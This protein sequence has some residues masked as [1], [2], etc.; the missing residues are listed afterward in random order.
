MMEFVLRERRDDL[1]NY[2]P[3]CFTCRHLDLDRLDARRCRAYP[4]G[5]PVPI[6]IGEHQ[7]RTPYP[8][9]GGIYFERTTAA[10]Q[11]VRQLRS[12][13][14]MQLRER[15]RARALA[16]RRGFVP[17]YLTAGL[18]ETVDVRVNMVQPVAE[19][20]TRELLLGQVTQWWLEGGEIRTYARARVE[21]FIPGDDENENKGSV[22]LTPII[23]EFWTGLDP[24]SE[25]DLCEGPTALAR[26]VVTRIERRGSPDPREVPRVVSADDGYIV[27]TLTLQ[28]TDDGEP[29]RPI[30]SGDIITC[31]V[32]WENDQTVASAVVEFDEIDRLAARGTATGRIM[33]L[34]SYLW[35]DVQV[36][37]ELR[38]STS[39]HGEQVGRAT[40][41]RIVRNLVASG[42]S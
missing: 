10:D 2:S 33:P 26:G 6:W 3:V 11:V 14:F 21:K 15:A 30:D 16:D 5:I 18:P 34:E 35:Q 22:T 27:A 36:G 41:T 42:V 32:P 39:S 28:E 40:V 23:P 24:G 19:G 4:D 29:V 9:D 37:S 12:R 25:L 31:Q 20:L 13:R 1:P 8:G 17:A 7:H 38:C